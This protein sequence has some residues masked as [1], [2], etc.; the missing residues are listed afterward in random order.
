MAALE[1]CLREHQGEYVRLIGIDAKAKRRILESIIQRPDGIVAPAG[2]TAT[3]SFSPAKSNSSTS[4]SSPSPTSSSNGLSSEVLDHLR[5][6]VSGGYKISA[7]YVDSR[8]FRTGTWQTCG[9]IE[10]SSDRQAAATLQG[11]I[12]EHPGDYVRLIGIDPKAKR[13]VLELIVQRP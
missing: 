3:T 6:L 12:S 4:Y 13:R 8:R 7:E 11:Y 2:N 1:N 5:Q 10:A 9:Q